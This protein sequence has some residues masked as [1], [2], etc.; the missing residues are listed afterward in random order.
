MKP[1]QVGLLQPNPRIQDPH[2]WPMPTVS[3]MVV[4]HDSHT[5]DTPPD[6]AIAKALATLI[7]YAVGPGQQGLPPGYV[8]LPDNLRRYARAV[9][10]TIGHGKLP[11]IPTQAPPTT[12]PPPPITQ[13]PVIIPPTTPPV[14]VSVTASPSPTPS[15]T[16]PPITRIFVTPTPPPVRLA[17]SSAAIV[18]PMLLILALAALV[19]GPSLLYGGKV[20]ARIAM[21]DRVRSAS[22]LGW[23]RRRVSAWRRR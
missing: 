7:T 2:V 22:P 19:T 13:P 12:P 14:S 3:Y 8:P 21:S 1:D 23:A 15:S 16:S 5:S 20:L 6:P 17:S 11:V 10:A 9:A 4:P 18:L